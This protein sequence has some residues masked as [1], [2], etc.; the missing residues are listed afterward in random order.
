MERVVSKRG[1][2][3]YVDTGQTGRSRA[4]V[5]PYSVRAVAGATVSTPLEWDEVHLALDPRAFT[6]RS[7]PARLAERPDPMATL[8]QVEPNLAEALARLE[9]LI[10]RPR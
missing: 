2:R 3:I 4:I 8:L 10:R 9:P 6:I 7:V 5:A 1:P